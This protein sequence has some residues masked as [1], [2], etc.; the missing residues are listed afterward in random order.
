MKSKK[1]IPLKPVQRFM[2]E[3]TTQRVSDFAVERT[4]EEL[5][6]IG[7]K[8]S[9]KAWDIAQH[10]GRK[11]ILAEDIALAYEQIKNN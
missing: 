5:I 6:Y 3:K 10:S 9:I 7:R 1:L 4:V 11:T 2:K 8:I